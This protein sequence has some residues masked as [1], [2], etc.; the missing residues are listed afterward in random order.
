MWRLR[1]GI[2]LGE[3]SYWIGVVQC[4]AGASEEPGAA[5]LDAALPAGGIKMGITIADRIAKTAKPTRTKKRGTRHFRF[6]L[7]IRTFLSLEST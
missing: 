4:W 5:A 7:F 2:K 1:H 3:S 6:G